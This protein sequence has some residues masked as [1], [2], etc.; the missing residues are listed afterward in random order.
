M[1]LEQNIFDHIFLNLVLVASLSLC[2]RCPFRNQQLFPRGQWR[3][4]V[5]INHRERELRRQ[6]IFRAH[7]FTDDDEDAIPA[8]IME[9]CEIHLK[10]P[11]TYLG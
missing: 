1:L 8:E 10:S 9:I 6:G 4:E 5:V 7:K 3:G 11:R 2:R